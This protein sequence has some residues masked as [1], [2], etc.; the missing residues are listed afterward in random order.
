MAR[1]ALAVGF[2]VLG[3]VTFG[4]TT[5][6]SLTLGASILFG[7]SLGFTVGSA[8]GQVLFPIHL[9]NQV[10]PRLNDLTVSSSTNG[11]FIP[12]GYGI[13]RFAGNIIYSPGLVE[14]SKTTKHSSKGGPSYKSTNYTYTCTFAVAFGESYPVVSGYGDIIKVWGDSKI[15]Y[16][17]TVVAL[18]I[19]YRG[20]YDPSNSYVV[21]D[22]VTTNDGKNW[23]AKGPNTGSI[24]APESV[25][26]SLVWDYYSGS[27]AVVA[28]QKYPAPTIYHGTETQMP[29]PTIQADKGVHA[30]PAFRGIIYAIWVDFLLSDFGNRIPNIQGL[31]Q[32]GTSASAPP[33]GDVIKD[34]TLRAGLNPDQIDVSQV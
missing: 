17:N 16:D 20:A 3:A 27:I 1:I 7:A 21:N 13:F 30:T 8:L 14:H 31:V 28:Q 6:F 18:G 32:F 23:K 10:G 19:N 2:A 24:F 5:P 25:F 22:V 34:I 12:I 11:A 15:L 4:L 33:L 26:G 29:D 9:P